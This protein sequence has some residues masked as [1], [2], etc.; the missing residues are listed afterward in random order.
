MTEIKRRRP[1][2]G[3]KVT[4]TLANM[5]GILRKKTIVDPE[6]DCWLWQ[7]AK[8]RKGYGH[9]LMDGRTENVQRI[10]AMLYLG[11]KEDQSYRHVL[12]R[13]P[14]KGCWNPE[15]LYLGDNFDNWADRKEDKNK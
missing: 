4:N 1:G 7:G 13:C 14:S 2:G 3:R 6:T 15:H 12:H 10:S 11:L 9:I 8:N 5:E